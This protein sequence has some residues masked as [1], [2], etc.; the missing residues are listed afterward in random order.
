MG[1]QYNF[2]LA[3]SIAFLILLFVLT[4]HVPF[5]WDAVSK[6][7][8]ATWLYNHDFSS[9]VV[10]TQLNS[11]HPPLWETLLA[12]SWKIGGR[13]IEVSR[14]LL[15]VF[16]MGVFWQLIRFI[17]S[18]KAAT[19]PFL[20][21]ILVLIEPT[22]LAQST[23]INNDMMLL[24]FTLLGLNSIS[25]NQKIL[26]AVALTGVLFSNLRGV[27]VFAS[28]LVIDFLFYRFKLKEKEQKFLGVS[29]IFPILIFGAFLA[30][31]QVVLGW[32]LKAPGHSHR[33]I[34]R[35]GHI[36]KNIAVILKSMLESGRLFVFL[37][38]GLLIIQILRLKKWE[39]LSAENKRLII[40]FFVFFLIFSALFVIMTNPL[41]PRYYMIC[42]LIA[43][44]LFLNLTFEFVQHIRWKKSLTGIAFFGYLT[45]HLWIWPA[46]IAQA[47][48]STLAY[49][50]Y[51]PLKNKMELY[52]SEK[53]LDKTET[54]TNLNFNEPEYI[55][56]KAPATVQYSKLDLS[57]NQYVIFSNIENSTSDEEIHILRNNWKLEKS[58]CQMGVFIELY[59]NPKLP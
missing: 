32:F 39:I 33:E 25:K 36:L 51:F 50:H 52:V 28:L 29:Y 54:G 4:L 18:N 27:S 23:I 45:A 13:T 48:D 31:Q 53:G 14:L 30:Y 7:V 16:N 49:L 12:L 26:F 5:F 56:L 46:T 59:K 57:Q 3:G 6:S 10:P 22:L 41:G 58:F 2:L 42:F 1:K 15:L 8:R 21:V 24:F 19:V 37:P 44:L 55:D 35:F 47:W 17:K 9:L 40:S 20:A 43:T 34:A 11:G 38:L